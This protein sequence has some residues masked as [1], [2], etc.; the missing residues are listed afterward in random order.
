MSLI[1]G[2]HRMTADISDVQLSHFRDELKWIIGPLLL[3]LPVHPQWFSLLLYVVIMVD[4]SN[5]K[6]MSTVSLEDSESSVSVCRWQ[7]D[8]VIV[9]LTGSLLAVRRT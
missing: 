4:N 2:L 7:C 9:S 1:V 3:S 6:K 8:T 5:S